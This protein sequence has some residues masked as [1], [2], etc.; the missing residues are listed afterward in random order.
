MNIR[1]F[2]ALPLKQTV[3]RRLA[4]HADS[5]CHLDL[6]GDILWVDSDNY[7]LTLGFLGDIKLRQ[8]NKLE[9]IATEMLAHTGSFQVHLGA[10]EYYRVN[11]QLG[12]VAA[13]ADPQAELMAVRNTIVAIIEAANVKTEQQNFKPHVTLGRMDGSKEFSQPE[14]WPSLDLP[15]LADSVVLY[16]SKMG[17]NG[18]IYTPLFAVPLGAADV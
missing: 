4:D 11:E 1:A 8:V 13:L 10:C 3:V 18:S 12:L 16:Q 7:H 2:F 15:S 6:N 9:A 5:L 14:H 17:A